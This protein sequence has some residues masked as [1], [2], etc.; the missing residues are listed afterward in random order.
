MKKLY[1]SPA[2]KEGSDA[3]I[4]VNRVHRPHPKRYMKKLDCS[5]SLHGIVMGLIVLFISIATLSAF[6][7]LKEGVEGE[8]NSVQLPNQEE[9]SSS[10][11]TSS[12]NDGNAEEIGPN[13]ILHTLLYNI[14]IV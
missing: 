9:N 5:H 1:F 3:K 6:Y 8:E 11:P 12:T 4:E 2:V 7:G 14:L 10:T 13:V